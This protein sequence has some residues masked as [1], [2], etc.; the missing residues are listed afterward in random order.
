MARN[1]NLE[2]GSFPLLDLSLQPSFHLVLRV[3]QVSETA[4]IKILARGIG[5]DRSGSS[6]GGDV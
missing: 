4:N 6:L 2:I 3:V 1:W 5:L